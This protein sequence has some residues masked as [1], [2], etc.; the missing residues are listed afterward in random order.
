M[1]CTNMLPRIEVKV[2]SFARVR[3][4]TNLT[5]L[6][7]SFVPP[8]TPVVRDKFGKKVGK[9]AGPGRVVVARMRER[10]FV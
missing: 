6:F 2:V 7:H 1:C 3:A 8:K 10:Y 4:K 9:V 5:N